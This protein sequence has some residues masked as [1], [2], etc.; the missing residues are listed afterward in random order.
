MNFNNFEDTEL[1]PHFILWQTH[2]AFNKRD[3][4]CYI[5][6]KNDKGAST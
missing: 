6:M 3:P 2:S 4:R 5:F 1:F